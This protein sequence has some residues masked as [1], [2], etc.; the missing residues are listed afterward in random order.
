MKDHLGNHKF[1]TVGTALEWRFLL[2]WGV[3]VF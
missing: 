2:F 3:M 1:K